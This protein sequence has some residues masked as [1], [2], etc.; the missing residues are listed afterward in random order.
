VFSG[1]FLSTT[2][3]G[4]GTTGALLSGGS[5]PLLNVATG[6]EVGGALIVIVAEFLEQQMLAIEEGER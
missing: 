5:I 3:A 4:H 2:F 6:L 1:A